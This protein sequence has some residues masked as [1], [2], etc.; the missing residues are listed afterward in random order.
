[1]VPTAS[2]DEQSEEP[3]DRSGEVSPRIGEW[4][5]ESLYTAKYADMVRLAYFLTGSIAQAEEATQDAFV[6]LYE[7]WSTVVN[8]PAYLRTSVVN[9]C[10]SWHRS[11][12][13]ARRRTGRRPLEC[14]RGGG[15]DLHN[16]RHTGRISGAVTGPPPSEPVG[17]RPRGPVT[18]ASLELT[19][20]RAE[21]DQ[22][23]PG[24]L[25]RGIL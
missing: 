14:R 2:A 11:R 21:Q 13:V 23:P 5:F 7:H 25:A 17:S 12:F 4:E 6:R 10:R 8:H 24:P 22:C 19:T 9:R 1:M 3:N 16:T 15:V 18:G 20:A